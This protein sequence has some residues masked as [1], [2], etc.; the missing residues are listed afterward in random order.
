MRIF[1]RI[2]FH[3]IWYATS[4]GI[5]SSRSEAEASRTASVP[6]PSWNQRRRRAGAS[7]GSQSSIGP[8]PARL[9]TIAS[10]PITITFASAT[11]SGRRRVA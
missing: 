3:S 8:M 5:R 4:V 9:K 6:S 7:S 1:T 2:L 11:S 10:W